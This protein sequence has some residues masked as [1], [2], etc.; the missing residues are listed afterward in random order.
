MGHGFHGKEKVA[1]IVCEFPQSLQ[2]CVA[3]RAAVA[4]GEW[5]AHSA[6][7]CVDDTDHVAALGDVDSN[8]EHNEHHCQRQFGIVRKR[9]DAGRFL[10]FIGNQGLLRPFLL[11]SSSQ[12]IRE[13]QRDLRNIG[14]KEQCQE[15]GDPKGHDPLDHIGK[16]HFCD[17]GHNHKPGANRRGGCPQQPH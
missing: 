6:P 5:F 1:L 7:L 14:D 11:N 12:Q 15:Q 8:D 13:P 9:P 3:A 2:Q 4:D 17:S 10:T 16:F